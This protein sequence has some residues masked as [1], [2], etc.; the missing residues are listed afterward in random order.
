[1]LL[2]NLNIFTNSRSKYITRLDELADKALTDM[3]FPQFL[4]ERR[5]DLNLCFSEECTG[6][7]SNTVEKV[8][9]QQLMLFVKFVK[10]I[11]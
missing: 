3:Q 1:M 10:Y 5:M 2:Y 11:H 6:E 8:T 9:I 7:V 4:I